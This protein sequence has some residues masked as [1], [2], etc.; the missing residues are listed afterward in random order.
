MKKEFPL[1][2]VLITNLPNATFVSS[3]ARKPSSSP[4]QTGSRKCS[5]SFRAGSVGHDPTQ[6]FD[7]GS[8]SCTCLRAVVCNHL[9]LGAP[10][11]ERRVAL[12]SNRTS[13]MATLVDLCAV[14]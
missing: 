11:L 10:A 8:T 13:G 4:A 12:E 5:G 7:L 9:K 3:P 1:G 14:R 6:R 2:R